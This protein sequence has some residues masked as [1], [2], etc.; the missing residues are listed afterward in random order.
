MYQPAKFW[1]SSDWKRNSSFTTLPRASGGRRLVTWDQSPVTPSIGSRM[2]ANSESSSASRT[3]S[4]P[5]SK[6]SSM[7]LNSKK[8]RVAP[9]A[10]VRSMGGERSQMSASIS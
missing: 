10:V 5:E 1:R 4:R 8:R 7:S 6:P 3:A 2:T 9:S